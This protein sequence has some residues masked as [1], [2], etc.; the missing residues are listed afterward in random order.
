[1]SARRRTSR[2]KRRS[3]LGQNFLSPDVAEQFVQAAQFKP[4]DIVVEVGAGRGSITKALATRR[5]EIIAVELDPVWADELRRKTRDLSMVRVLETDILKFR[6]PKKPFRL[7][8]NIPFG[9]TTNILRKF[10]DDPTSSLT[11]LDIIVQWEVALKRSQ[12]PP[13]TLLSTSW[14]PW[15]DVQLGQK[16]QA[17]AFHPRPKTDAGMLSFVRRTPPLLPVE[18]AAEYAGFVRQNWPFAVV[19]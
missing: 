16:I 11:R 9:Q 12:A 1:M 2:D 18:M 8:G 3:R 13:S 6:L 7:I 10:L 19:K 14:S 17:D 5:L 15:W 4:G